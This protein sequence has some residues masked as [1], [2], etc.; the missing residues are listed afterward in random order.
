MSRPVVWDGGAVRQKVNSGWWR[1]ESYLIDTLRILSEAP[2]FRP[3]SAAPSHGP[4]SSLAPH[5]ISLRHPAL[6][7]GV[8]IAPL[9]I[10]LRLRLG[11][12]DSPSRGE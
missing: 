3:V 8:A 5:R 9:R 11:F 10:S 2:L 6:L 4:E 12:C 1:V 7:C